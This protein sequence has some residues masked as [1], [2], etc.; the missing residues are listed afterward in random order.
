MNSYMIIRTGWKPYS[1]NQNLYNL[2]H[3]ETDSTLLHLWDRDF[4]ADIN[5]SFKVFE[6]TSWK[7]EWTI[8][9]EAGQWWKLLEENERLHFSLI[10]VMQLDSALSIK[11]VSHL[12][13][14]FRQMKG[15][16]EHTSATCNPRRQK[17]HRREIFKLET[18]QDSEE[19]STKQGTKVSQVRSMKNIPA[20][21][22]VIAKK[23]FVVSMLEGKMNDGG[24]W[25]YIE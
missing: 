5:W 20:S 17:D 18:W 8:L 15:I 21:F 14:H 7:D 25:L 3:F 11:L 2:L 24:V 4:S 10:K 19:V 1:E 22:L 23:H 12:Q 13:N 6:K 9:D 16:V